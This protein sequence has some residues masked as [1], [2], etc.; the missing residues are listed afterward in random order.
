LNGI[1][2]V[3]TDHAIW[4]SRPAAAGFASLGLAEAAGAALP[5][6]GGAPSDF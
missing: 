1:Q 2:P 6:A 3:H 4:N 5:G